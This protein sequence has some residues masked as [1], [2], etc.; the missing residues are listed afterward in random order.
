MLTKVATA[1]TENG[2][3]QGP[4]AGTVIQIIWKEKHMMTAEKMEVLNSF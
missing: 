1:F 3:K 4:Q 2:Q